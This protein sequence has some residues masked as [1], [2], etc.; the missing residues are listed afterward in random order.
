MS[1]ELL[2]C[3]ANLLLEDLHAR[4]RIIDNLVAEGKR[5]GRI[6]W[7]CDGSIECAAA[8]ILSYYGITERETMEGTVA[9]R[10]VVT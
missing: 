1:G 7:C 10:G 5:I 8:R 9:R 2:D 4:N 6:P 3:I